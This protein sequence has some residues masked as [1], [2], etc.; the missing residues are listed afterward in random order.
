MIGLCRLSWAVA[1]HAGMLSPVRILSTSQALSPS[2]VLG[3]DI[4]PGSTLLEPRRRVPRH[5]RA[6][7]PPDFPNGSRFT[8][9]SSSRAFHLYLYLVDTRE[10]L[11]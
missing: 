4:G 9:H 8:V 2:V 6:H 10:T 7:T 11:Q 3:P 5:P 1:I